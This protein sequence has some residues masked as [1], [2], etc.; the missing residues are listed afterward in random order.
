MT[1]QKQ[2]R[3]QINS[4]NRIERIY[5]VR[6]LQFLGESLK[7]IYFIFEK[8]NLKTL[9]LKQFLVRLSKEVLKEKESVNSGKSITTQKLPSPKLCQNENE[10]SNEKSVKDFEEFIKS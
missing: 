6:N 7:K 3:G 1:L 2:A 10:L 5:G 4:D 8:H 9:W